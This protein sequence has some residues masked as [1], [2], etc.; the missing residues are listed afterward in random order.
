MKGEI[1]NDNKRRIRSSNCRNDLG[2]PEL[3]VQPDYVSAVAGTGREEG[4]LS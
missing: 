1:R 4:G 2:R 3:A